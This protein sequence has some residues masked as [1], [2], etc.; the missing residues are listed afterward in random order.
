MKDSITNQFDNVKR[1]MDETVKQLK[2]KIDDQEQTIG[3]LEE[4]NKEY[5]RKEDVTLD[6]FNESGVKDHEHLMYII[7]EYNYNLH[8]DSDFLNTLKEVKDE[9]FNIRH[10]LF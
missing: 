8:N 5:K 2:A 1:I 3:K 9:L 7:N 6:F 4:E 10:D